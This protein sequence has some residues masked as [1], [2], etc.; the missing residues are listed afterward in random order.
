MYSQVT[1]GPFTDRPI[2]VKM[3]QRRPEAGPLRSSGPRT[4]LIPLLA[5]LFAVVTFGV[6]FGAG[7]GGSSLNAPAPPPSC[8]DEFSKLRWSSVS[9]DMIGPESAIAIDQG[10]HRA[11]PSYSGAG[12]G[13]CIAR[14][15]DE[16]TR[17]ELVLPTRRARRLTT[18]S[19]EDD[20][21]SDL[22]VTVPS[23][24]SSSAESIVWG[25]L[26][27]MSDYFKIK[28]TTAHIK[29]VTGRLVTKSFPGLYYCGKTYQR[30]P[31]SPIY[32]LT[33]KAQ[34]PEA[35]NATMPWSESYPQGWTG[36]QLCSIHK[37]CCVFAW[38]AICQEGVD[39]CSDYPP[40]SPSPPPAPPSFPILP[41]TGTNVTTMTVSKKIVELP[42]TGWRVPFT[43]ETHIVET[44]DDLNNWKHT[45]D[46]NS[47]GCFDLW[48][49]PTGQVRGPN[50]VSINDAVCADYYSCN[51]YGGRCQQCSCWGEARP[52]CLPPSNSGHP[53]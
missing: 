16:L 7:W 11:N 30:N 48:W 5:L 1:S 4:S 38:G 28:A 18:S 24:T 43:T 19:E 53:S 41:C 44:C 9:R 33:N 8:V 47:D 29:M 34:G 20:D 26:D 2:D 46:T 45:H 27:D 42:C 50:Q 22:L 23:S 49:A 25:T 35:G 51:G 14:V 36:W 15:H 37:A 17:K 12:D 31:D 21:Y 52:E 6:G 13:S 40:P 3:G 39:A 32:A 10:E